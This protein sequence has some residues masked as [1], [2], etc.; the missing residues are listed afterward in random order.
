MAILS[1]G[2]TFLFISGLLVFF[3]FIPDSFLEI[4][5]YTVIFLFVVV[6]IFQHRILF[7]KSANLLAI[8]WTLLFLINVLL[9]NL[10]WITDAF[11]VT[12]KIII[13]FGV[14]DYDFVVIADRAQERRFPAPEA[15]YGIEGSL[16]LLI[17]SE[18]SNATLRE[19]NWIKKKA[20]ENVKEGIETIVFAFQDVFPH[21]ELRAI[22]W[23]NPEKVSVYLF[24][25]SAQKVKSEFIV[26]PMGLA[27][28]GFALSQAT[29]Q[30]QK[31][32][33]G[34]TVV[35]LHLSLLI[36]VFGAEAVYNMLLNKM[37]YI[38]ENGITL[39]A[40]FYPT[41]HSD[42]SIVSLFTR[43]ADESIKL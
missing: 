12:A 6:A 19:G 32:D 7:G 9:Q 17:S 14:L 5:G 40:V 38:R 2:L 1:I 11:A 8:G 34:C 13:L 37:G 23:V 18:N 39:Y 21:Q 4:I 43:L 25:S 31:T 41:M 10:G 30:C 36:Q 20:S 22:N 42:P 33:K 35:F 16:K 24:S 27:Q 29:S 15:G 26:L 3:D 28:I